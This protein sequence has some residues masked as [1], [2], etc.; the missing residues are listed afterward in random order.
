MRIPINLIT[1]YADLVQD[2]HMRVERPASLY[3]RIIKGTEYTY[4]K[5][6]VGTVRRDIFIGPTSDDATQARIAQIQTETARGADR[7]KTIAA[8]RAGGIPVQTTE[9]GLVLDALDDAGL[10]K[11]TVVVGTS[12]YISYAP[13][14]GTLLPQASLSTED[15]DIATMSLAISADDVTD[16]FEAVLK[17]ADPTYAG[18]LGLDP[19]SY[20]SRFRAQSGFTVDL[21]TPVLR[22]EDPNPI[23]MK[24]LQAS[25]ATLQYLRWLIAEPIQAASLYGSGQ[26]IFIPQPARYAVHKLIVA[27]KRT[28]NLIKRQKDLAQAKALI[29]VL[30][31]RDPYALSD[32]RDA[33]FAEGFEGWQVP[34]ERSLSE[35][36]LDVEFEAASF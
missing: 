8:L 4:A 10:L 24:N 14:V 19:R 22:R 16:S 28:H 33:A 18:M 26:P 21:L 7:R 6:Q 20:P 30:I 15:A 32:A 17:R 36:G 34:I 3:N 12:A 31:R 35:L 25:A 13:F 29:D 23:P 5:R 1:L 9:L 27:Q 2:L 11:N